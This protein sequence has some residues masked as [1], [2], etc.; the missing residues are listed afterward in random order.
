VRRY[1]TQKRDIIVGLMAIRLRPTGAKDDPTGDVFVTGLLRSGRVNDPALATLLRDKGLS[2]DTLRHSA[3]S[4]GADKLMGL[5]NSIA[6]QLKMFAGFQASYEHLV[7]RKLY[8]QR[9]EL[10]NQV[11]GRDLSAID[12]QTVT[13][14][15]SEPQTKPSKAP[16]Q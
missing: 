14:I 13:A 10:Q 6:M 5:D 1:E 7:T 8:V 16:R 9:L 3:F 11:L 15:T 12:V 4:I 2:M